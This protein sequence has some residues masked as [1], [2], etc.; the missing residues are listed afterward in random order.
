MELPLLK[1]NIEKLIPHRGK[2]LLIDRITAWSDTDIC[3]ESDIKE[4][5][6]FYDE[7]CGGLP[8][9]VG[10]EIMAQ[11]A[12]AQS[13]LLAYK[14]GEKLESKFGMILSVKKMTS[15]KDFL[16]LNSTIVTKVSQDDVE[17]G[18]YTFSGE[19]FVKN[20]DSLEKIMDATLTAIQTEV[21]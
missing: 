10:F 6:L 21:K 4:S 18:L 8:A 19:I 9:Y 20:N 13:R 11:A 16:P 3:C 1:D 12:A 7:V 17:G 14:R 5:N 2:M 15:E